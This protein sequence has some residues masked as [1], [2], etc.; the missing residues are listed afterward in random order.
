ML[1]ISWSLEP[2]VPVVTTGL[3]P[4]QWPQR[5]R[6]DLLQEQVLALFS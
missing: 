3:H 4:L 5:S 2:C 6:L 1:V